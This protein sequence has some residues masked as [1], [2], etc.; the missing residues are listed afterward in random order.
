MN[1]KKLQLSK[2]IHPRQSNAA[3]TNMT[4]SGVQTQMMIL[5]EYVET[6]RWFLALM[7]IRA[8]RNLLLRESNPE[9]FDVA[10]LMYVASVITMYQ[11]TTDVNWDMGMRGVGDDARE[12]LQRYDTPNSGAEALLRNALTSVDRGV[13]CS[14]PIH[15][16]ISARHIDIITLAKIDG[17]EEWLSTHC[18]GRHVQ[19]NIG[20]GVSLSPTIHP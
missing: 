20:G 6:G 1:L 9:D 7:F 4:D 15:F 3:D 18:R 13:R 11:N 16:Q 14:L 12:Y 17:W 2:L 10:R 5:S 19:A 8:N